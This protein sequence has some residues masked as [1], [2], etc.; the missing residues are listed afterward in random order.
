MTKG[1]QKCKDLG[2]K[3][4]L[5]QAD[6][7]ALKGVGTWWLEETERLGCTKGQGREPERDGGR[8]TGRRPSSVLLPWET[9]TVQTQSNAK[10]S[11]SK[12][13]ALWKM[14]Q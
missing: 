6:G 3:G 1:T 7:R 8:G 9:Q 2:R 10:T 11:A 13:G 5:F 14:R 4:R 12:Q